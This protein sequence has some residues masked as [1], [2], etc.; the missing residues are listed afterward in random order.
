MTDAYRTTPP[1]SGGTRTGTADPVRDES[2][3]LRGDVADAGRT[4]AESA[5]DEA[6]GVVGEARAQLSTLVEQ[7]T[8]ELQEQAATQKDR[9]SAGLR[10][11]SD[12]LRSMAG[13]ASGGI[14][15]DIVSQASSRAGSLASWLD[16]HEPRSVLGEVKN[17]ARRRPGTFIAI[18]AGVGILAGRLTRSAAENAGDATRNS[19][20]VP[21]RVPARSEFRAA[22]P[23]QTGQD[24]QT[25]QGVGTSAT[26]DGGPSYLSETNTVPD[27]G[28][29]EFGVGRAQL[30]RE[31]GR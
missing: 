4:V 23:Y 19:T 6:A 7:V 24:Y 16:G 14:A 9:A 31:E 29:D 25:G 27:E 30:P 3:K 12:D 1:A 20:G 10:T 2:E 15:A 13:T 8:G 21:A 17:F 18:A 22:A 11:M 28:I 5:K 26:A